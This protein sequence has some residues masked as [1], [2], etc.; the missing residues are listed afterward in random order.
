ME[1]QGDLL[2]DYFALKFMR[3]PRIVRQ[4]RHA[5]QLELYEQVLAG[6][7]ADPLDRENLP[8]G[9]ARRLMRA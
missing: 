4:R 5:H 7:L 3:Q 2:A 6:F 8:H 1:A 9:A